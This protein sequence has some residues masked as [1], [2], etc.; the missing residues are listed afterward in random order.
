MGDW[1]PGPARDSRA[2]FNFIADFGNPDLSF[3]PVTGWALDPAGPWHIARFLHLYTSRLEDPAWDLNCDVEAPVIRQ[4]MIRTK[5]L[6]RTQARQLA[7]HDGAHWIHMTSR[8]VYWWV[9]E[10]VELFWLRTRRTVRRM[11]P[12]RISAGVRR[13]LDRRG[14]TPDSVE[15]PTPDDSSTSRNDDVAAP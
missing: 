11:N 14:D 9:R 13:R 15:V 7:V 2:E 8:D 4:S 1:Q 12:D 5:R 10:R 6:R 3:D